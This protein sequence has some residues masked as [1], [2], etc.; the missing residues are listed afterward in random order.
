MGIALERLE[1]NSVTDRNFLT[2]AEIVVDTGGQSVGV[3]FGAN[4]AT[5]S[6]SPTSATKT[7]AHGLGRTPGAVFVSATGTGFL[8]YSEAS[9]SNSTNI[10]ISGTDTRNTSLTGTFAFYWLVIG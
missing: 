5:W 6:A 8:L 4:S 9:A 7:I 1:D 10:F 2:L 3:R